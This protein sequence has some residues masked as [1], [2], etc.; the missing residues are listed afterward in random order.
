MTTSRPMPTER[1]VTP[2]TANQRMLAV[3]MVLGVTLVAFEATALITAL[4]TITDELGGD[5]LYGVSLAIYTLANMAA[6]VI[7]GQW[8]DRFGP[9]PVFTWS[10]V[11]FAV[12]LAVAGLASSMAMVV[13]GRGLQGLGSGGFS[14]IA[15]MLVRR[16]FP[17]DRQAKMYIYISAGWV[18]PSLVAPLFAGWITD[19]F[20]WRWVFLLLL[21]LALV[22]GVAGSRPMREHGPTPVDGPGAPSLARPAIAA[23]AG[24]GLVMVALAESSTLVQ[25]GGLIIG[26]AVAIPALRRLLPRGFFTG[27]AG[28]PAV[29]TCRM[30]AAA[31]FIGV[32]SFVPLAAD[33]IHGASPTVQGFVIVGGALCWTG[34]QMLINRFPGVSA[35]QAALAGFAIIALATALVTPVLWSGWPLWAV[36]IGWCIGGIGMGVQYNPSTVAAMSYATDGTE[37]MVSGQA[38]LTDALGFSLMY[39]I[40]GAVVAVADRGGITI[41][42]AIA[43]NFALAFGIA[44]LGMVVS[45]GVRVAE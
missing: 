23:A 32:D 24:V 42:T 5:S 19:Q 3:S 13:L 37:G 18:V 11:L 43:V 31:T 30:L 27:T 40:G 20:G 38:R 45:R 8:A 4:P 35:R 16:A 10:V 15:Y 17:A 1:A 29:L 22:V 21:P 12:G 14:P 25:L 6:L 41:T 28:Y 33:R 34:G 26:I 2:L 44:V 36:F 9:R 7:S 39:G